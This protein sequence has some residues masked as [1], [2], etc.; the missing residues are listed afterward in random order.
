M[1]TFGKFSGV[2]ETIGV[3]Q[4]GRRGKKAAYLDSFLKEFCYKADQKKG[5]SLEKDMGLGEAFFF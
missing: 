2:V 5:D 3:L 4:N 1:I